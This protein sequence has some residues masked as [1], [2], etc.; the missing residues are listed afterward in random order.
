MSRAPGAIRDATATYAPASVASRMAP[1][2]RLIAVGYPRLFAEG[3]RGYRPDPSV[4]GAPA[5]RVGVTPL[6]TPIRV[7]RAG[8]RF[9]DASVDRLNTAIRDGVAEAAS[10]LAGAGATQQVGFVASDPAFAGHRLCNAS[11]WVNGVEITALGVPKRIS[12]HPNA[13]GQAAYARAVGAALAA[14][15]T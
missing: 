15:P 11:P 1:G 4:G 12:L 2:A 14:T 5:C 3:G 7:T 13:K 9:L 6:H 10:R 8:A